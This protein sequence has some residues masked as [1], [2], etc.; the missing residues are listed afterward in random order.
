MARSRR[1]IR[2]TRTIPIDTDDEKDDNESA[3]ER[4][5]SEDDAD[6]SNEEPLKKKFKAI[7]VGCAMDDKEGADRVSESKK[8][9]KTAGFC[10]V[11]CTLFSV[12]RHPFEHENPPNLPKPQTLNSK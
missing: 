4:S 9:H 8:Q 3:D 1:R 6:D 2:A 5:A 7:K 10:V 12:S 11:N